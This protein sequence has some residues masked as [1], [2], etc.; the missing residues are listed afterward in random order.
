MSFRAVLRVAG[1]LAGSM[2]A[3]FAACTFSLTP[4]SASFSSASN[5]AVVQISASASNCAWTSSVNGAAWITISFGTSGTGNGSMGFTVLQNNAFSPRS[6]SL[7]IAGM[8]FPVTQAAAPCTYN[9]SPNNATVSANGAS[10]SFNV[11]SGCNWSAT[12]NNPDWLTASGS[13]TGNGSVMYSAAPNPNFTSRAGTISVG[14]QTFTLTQS[15]ACAFTLNPVSAQVN[16]SGGSGTFQVQPSSSSCSWTASSNNPDFVT[17]TSGLTGTGNGTVG[18]TVLANMATD[19]RG[20]SI[21]VG[22]TAFGIYQPGGSPC[23][24]TL[25]PGSASYSSSG[26]AG[27]FNVTSNCPWTPTT[28]ADRIVI[29]SPATSSGNDVVHYGTLANP[30]SASRTGSIIIG[31]QAFTI[32]ETGVPCAVTVSQASITAAAAGA[33]GAIDVTAP[34][35]CNWTATSSVNWITFASANG[36]GQGVVSYTVAANTTPQARSAAITIANQVIKVTQ[37]GSPCGQTL[38]PDR[39]SL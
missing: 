38:T 36:S 33:M 27:N 26:G 32:S 14:T 35:S 30:T 19:P 5:D 1:L 6:G 31:T 22:N 7:T 29:G 9:L 15:A 2:P 20:G 21:A 11:T 23:S 37:D 12:S 10:G 13:G 24:Y 8:N 4:T 3:V 18:Y 25:V 28:T 34:D 17:V 16:P 39:A